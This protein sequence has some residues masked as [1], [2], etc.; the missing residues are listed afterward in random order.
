MHH[1]LP[2]QLKEAVLHQALRDEL[3]DH[4]DVFDYEI[5]LP[6]DL[7]SRIDALNASSGIDEDWGR[8]SETRGGAWPKGK[9]KGKAKATAAT[10][11]AAAKAKAHDDL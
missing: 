8:G 1:S 3:A 10:A 2:P 6:T 9:A 4:A 5:D 11:K 7:V